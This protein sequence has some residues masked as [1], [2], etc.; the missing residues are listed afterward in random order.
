MGAGG[1]LGNEANDIPWLSWWTKMSGR[2]DVL[3]NLGLQFALL[4]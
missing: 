1:K 4:Q 2:E 3:C